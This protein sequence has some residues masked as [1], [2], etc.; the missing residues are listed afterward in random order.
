MC[1]LGQVEVSGGRLAYLFMTEGPEYAD[2][3]WEPEGGENACLVQPGPVPSFVRVADRATG[4]TYGPDFAVA[5]SARAGV[6][7]CRDNQIGGDPAWLQHPEWPEGDGWRPLC[8]LALLPFAAQPNFGDAGTA[9]AF[10][11]EGSGEGRLLW[12]CH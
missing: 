7:T 10:V 12:Q 8:Q 1:F 4:P 3:T 11:D 2:G 9:Y 5:L 6:V